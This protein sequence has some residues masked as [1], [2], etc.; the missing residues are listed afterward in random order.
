MKGIK[1]LQL[2]AKLLAI[3]N[4][5]KEI[6]KEWHDLEAKKSLILSKLNGT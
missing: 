1:K 3:R 2:M 6:F 4:E 5:Q